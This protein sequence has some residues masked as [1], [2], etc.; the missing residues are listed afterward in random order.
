MVSSLEL[1]LHALEHGLEALCIADGSPA[2][3]QEMDARPDCDERRVLVQAETLHEHFEGHLVPDVGELRAVEVI[4]DGLARQVAR[5]IEPDEF[6]L[7]IDG[8]A[9]EPCARKPVLPRDPCGLPRLGPGTA[10]GRL[11]AA[12]DAIRAAR[13]EQRYRDTR[14][15]AS[16]TA[17]AALRLGGAREEVDCGQL[18]ELTLEAIERVFALRDQDGEVGRARI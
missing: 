15:Q 4:A 13:P 11:D 2:D 5:P 3:V 16:K 17:S 9:Y 14:A 8:A 6:R 7:G 18:V 12:F 10:S 1:F